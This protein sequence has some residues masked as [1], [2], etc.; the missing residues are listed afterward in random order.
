M[1][2]ALAALLDEPAAPPASGEG[3]GG[4][5]QPDDDAPGRPGAGPRPEGDR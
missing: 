4:E 1:D 3:A 2:A 5:E